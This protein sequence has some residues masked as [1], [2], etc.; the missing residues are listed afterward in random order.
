MEY[1]EAKLQLRPADKKVES[2]VR[3]WIN[4]RK[5]VS[6][7]KV[8]KLREGVDIY[9]SSNRFAIVMGRRLKKNFKGDLKISRKLHTL[10]KLRSK[11]VYRVTVCFRLN[12]D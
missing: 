2:L 1:F 9:L 7:A 5:D 12:E 4:N 6:I 8:D 3:K 10:D 11:R